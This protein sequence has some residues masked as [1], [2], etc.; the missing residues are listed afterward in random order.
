MYVIKY[1]LFYVKTNTVKNIINLL[2]S[3]FL[4]VSVFNG[5]L[6]SALPCSLQNEMIFINLRSLSVRFGWENEIIESK[7]Y[8]IQTK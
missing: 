5:Q 7:I 6:N 1:Y 8:S 2:F 3:Y 4:L